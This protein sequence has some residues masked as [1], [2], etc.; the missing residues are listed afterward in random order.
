MRNLIRFLK[1]N[2]QLDG[3]AGDT[4]DYT[5]TWGS[6]TSGCTVLQSA[7]T[8]TGRYSR[9][10]L[11]L[12]Y[13]IHSSASRR[14]RDISVWPQ[15]GHF[16]NGAWGGSSRTALGVESVVWT[17]TFI[18]LHFFVTRLVDILLLCWRTFHSGPAVF[19]HVWCNMFDATFR[20]GAAASSPDP[21]SLTRVHCNQR[22]TTGTSLRV[23]VPS[24]V[25]FSKEIK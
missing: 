18:F 16:N 6:V 9:W 22:Q 24:H 13:S 25:A 7:P 10:W 17:G 19:H 3:S 5:F 1:L 15:E 2:V 14:Q 20:R 21:G 11:L 12:K 23:C 4:T 8:L